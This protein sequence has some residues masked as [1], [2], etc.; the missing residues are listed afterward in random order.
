MDA[1]NADNRFQLPMMMIFLFL[2]LVMSSML[3]S[4][5]PEYSFQ[6]RSYV[7]PAESSFLNSVTE[8]GGDGRSRAGL[9]TRY[10]VHL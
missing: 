10:L 2:T 6:R 9:A 7:Q 8:L 1:G 5:Q 3:S 4:D